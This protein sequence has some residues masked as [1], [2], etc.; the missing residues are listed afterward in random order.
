MRRSSTARTGRIAGP[1]S[2]AL[3]TTLTLALAAGLL[4][5]TVGA[6]VAQAAAYR[7]WGYFQW[8]DGAWTLASVGPASVT[9]ADG[10]VEGWRFAVSPEN[11]APRLPRAAGDFEQ[12]CGST[13]AQA[14]HKRVA[15]VVD[16]GLAADA[17]SGESVPKP[18]GACAVVDPK[19][20]SAQVVAAVAEVRE[21]KGIICA[22][23]SF[24]ST[25]C[26][27]PV[28]K[29]PAVPSPEPTVQLVLPAAATPS[30][31]ATARNAA[32]QGPD[33]A[34]PSAASDSDGDSFPIL[35]VLAVVLVIVLVAGGVAVRRHRGAEQD[36]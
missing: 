27:D 18:R 14:G 6:G 34:A 3:L 11:S 24:P 22:I 9:P 32:D 19:A 10:A 30:P 5:T 23:D 13:P 7:Y 8:M 16:A 1:L 4:T 17:P 12:I 15:L 35:P 33:A 26:G 31:T 36:S 20:T 25:G 29:V 21:Q 28:D 2:T